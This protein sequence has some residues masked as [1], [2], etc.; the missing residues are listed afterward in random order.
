MKKDFELIEEKMDESSIIG[1]GAEAF[2]NSIK[3][4]IKIAAFKFLRSKQQTQ[5]KVRD[6]Q[7]LKLET[8]KYLLNRLFSNEEV[9]TLYSL[10]SRSLECKA[11]FKNKYKEGDTSCPLCEI[12]IDDQKKCSSALKY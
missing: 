1:C 6:I 2:K 10:R 12:H 7:F 11:N 4:K 8:Q 5:S 9:N 3:K